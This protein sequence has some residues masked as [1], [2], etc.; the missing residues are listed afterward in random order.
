MSF[1]NYHFSFILNLRNGQKTKKD[2]M[3]KLDVVLNC[4]NVLYN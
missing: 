3:K 1:L 2:D 4:F